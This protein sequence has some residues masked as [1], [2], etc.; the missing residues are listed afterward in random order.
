MQYRKTRRAASIEPLEDRTLLSVSL[1]KDINTIGVGSNPASF[2]TLNGNLLFSATDAAH[3]RELWRSDGTAAGTQLMGDL[4]PGSASSN[5]QA[6]TNI[7]GT[8]YFAADPGNGMGI[9]KTALFPG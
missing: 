2:A 9:W 7:G 3:G 1:L 4:N 8:A 5:P 6:L